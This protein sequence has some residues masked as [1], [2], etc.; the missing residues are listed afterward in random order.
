MKTENEHHKRKRNKRNK[1]NTKGKR[2]KKIA[3]LEAEALQAA[4]PNRNSQ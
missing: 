3:G 1:E 2:E 4:I